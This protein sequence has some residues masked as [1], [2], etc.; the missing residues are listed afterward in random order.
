MQPSVRQPTAHR[1]SRLQH[2]RRHCRHFE[3]A[4]ID[5]RWSL[6]DLGLVSSAVSIAIRLN[7]CRTRRWHLDFQKA[8]QAETGANV[9]FLFED[10]PICLPLVELLL[11][12]EKLVYFHTGPSPVDIVNVR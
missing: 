7:S 9:F 2:R 1:P 8:L 11:D 12:L 5:E 3:N 6:P 4:A 10:G